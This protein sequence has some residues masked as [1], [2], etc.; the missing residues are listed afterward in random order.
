MS[1]S[2]RSCRRPER[3]R[4]RAEARLGRLIGLEPNLQVGSKSGDPD[5]PLGAIAGGL[6]F[7]ADLRSRGFAQGSSACRTGLRRQDRSLPTQT[8]AAPSM[9]RYRSEPS[10]NQSWMVSSY[11]WQ[12]GG[13]SRVAPP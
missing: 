11:A 3:T 10:E 1:V 5:L 6:I 7:V 13:D 9:P 12:F 4:A 8:I 2:D